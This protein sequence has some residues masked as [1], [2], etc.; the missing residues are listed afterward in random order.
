MS[1]VKSTK[2]IANQISQLMLDKKASDIKIID[3]RKI[4]T[5]TDFFIICSSDSE[6]KTKAITSYISETLKDHGIR[7]LNIEGYNYLDW[8]LL[9]YVNIV[10]HIFSKKARDFYNFE[11]LWADASVKSIK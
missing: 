7:P 4:T 10:A 8:V 6:P 3:V 5:L 2:H 9:D 1:K 11:G